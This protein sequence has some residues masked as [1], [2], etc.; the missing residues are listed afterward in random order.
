MLNTTDTVRVFEVRQEYDV[1]GLTVAEAS[2]DLDQRHADFVALYKP[3]HPQ[4][5]GYWVRDVAASARCPWG[6]TWFTTG[7]DGRLAQ[8]QAHWDSSG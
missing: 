4:G 5:P 3:S 7:Q 6:Y 1:E 8:Y 2:A